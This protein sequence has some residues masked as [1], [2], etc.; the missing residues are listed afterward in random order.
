VKVAISAKDQNPEAQVDPRFGRCSYF[1]VVDV[2]QDRWDFIPNP[3]LSS[4]GGA[5]T[6]AAQELANKKVQVVLT[7]S[8]GP[9]AVAVLE[10]AG[11]EVYTGVSGT[12]QEAFTLYR[13]G[14]LAPAAGG[15]ARCSRS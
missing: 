1:A 4:G 8:A 6:H 5:G 15:I 11:I 13:K 14:H 7:G 10:A 9:N 2:E 3:G 12:L